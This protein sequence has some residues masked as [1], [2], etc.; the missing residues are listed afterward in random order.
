[1]SPETIKKLKEKFSLDDAAAKKK[2]EAIRKNVLKGIEAIKAE[3]AE[4]GKC[5]EKIFNAGRI[6]IGF[7][8]PDAFART[9]EDGKTDCD[10]PINLNLPILDCAEQP[11]YQG[12]SIFLLLNLIH[13]GRHAVQDYGAP[14]QARSE[15]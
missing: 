3:N 1:A 4:I 15:E 6:C 12:I 13:E 11:L 5:L 7:K 2:L 14:A 10:D 8:D 9:L